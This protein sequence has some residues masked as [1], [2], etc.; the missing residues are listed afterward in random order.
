MDQLYHCSTTN[1]Y[2]N[3]YISIKQIKQIKNRKFYCRWIKSALWIIW[4]SWAAHK[5]IYYVVPYLS[6]S[7]LADR[8]PR[9][10]FAKAAVSFPS[11]AFYLQL[12]VSQV[13]A[14]NT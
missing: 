1:D 14:H 12:E 13:Q 4:A 7:T 11:R 6:T 5:A 8:P 2:I 9:E 10:N 3:Y